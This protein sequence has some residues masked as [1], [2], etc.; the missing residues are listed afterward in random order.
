MRFEARRIFGSVLKVN[1]AYKSVIIPDL[2]KPHRNA[3][4][5]IKRRNVTKFLNKQKV[6]LQVISN[7]LIYS[8]Q[9]S[10]FNEI[11]VI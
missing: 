4:H 1:S 5:Y 7:I 8:K 3:S 9:L 2:S 6:P 10:P 11:E